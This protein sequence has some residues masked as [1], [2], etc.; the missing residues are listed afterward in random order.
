MRLKFLFALSV[1]GLLLGL[2]AAHISA[3]QPPAQTP[4]F[5][6]APDPYPNGIYATGI[7]ESRQT[8]GA[9]ISIN[10]EVSGPITRVFVAEGDVVKAGDPLL[11]ID[12]SV[13]RQTTE[14]LKAQAE[15]AE[16]MLAE[17]KAE[18][19]KETL[20]VA[21]AQVANAK[22]TLKNAADT[23]AKQER[24]FALDPQSVSQDTL[25]TARNTAK[26]AA[27]NLEVIER[28]EALTRAGA[29]I[30]DVENQERTYEALSRSA[31]AAGAL[32]AKYTIRAPADGVVLSIEAAAGSYVSSTGAYDTYTQGYLPLI[33]MGSP[34]GEFEVR[35]Y[36]DEILINRLPPTGQIAA[37]MYVQ[38]TDINVPLAFERMQPYVSPKIELS[39]QR[40]EQVDVR[41]LP[42]IFRLDKPDNVTLYPGQL[43]DV[44]I[45]QAPA[46]PGGAQKAAAP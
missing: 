40:L 7:V 31:A 30:Y 34:P 4:V 29:W 44:Y 33:V 46:A 1:L 3:Q 5:N 9:N 39:D 25:D 23:L 8:H 45:G 35:C 10:P 13:Q 14:Q 6:P 27:T 38:G 16:K 22:A 28:Q 41:V 18:P 2:Y 17:L 36:V 20:D 12:D 24:S 37:R 43:V 42:I 32:L 15:A 19:R 11:A 21:V 26:V